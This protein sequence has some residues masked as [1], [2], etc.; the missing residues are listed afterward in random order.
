MDVKTA[1][2]NCPLKEE[3]FVNQPYGFVEPHHPNKV[4]HLK[5]A[6]YGLKQAPKAWLYLDT[7][8]STSEA[9]YVSLS[10]CCAQGS[11]VE[12]GYWDYALSKKYDIVTGLPKLK[13]VKDHL[14]SSCELG[15]AKLQEQGETSSRYVDSSNMHT[16]YQRHPSEHHWTNDHSSEQVIGNPSQ[17][18]RTRRQLKTDGEMCMFALTMS[19]TEM[20]NIK[21]A[22]ADSV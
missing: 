6:L 13:F 19:R 21:E 3:V 20:K 9:V 2:L 17:S 5:K 8:K 18:I 4:Y 22:M 1:F 16:F 12:Q 15:K 11:M 14:C 7:R 10:A